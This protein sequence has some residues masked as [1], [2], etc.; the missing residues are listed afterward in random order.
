MRHDSLLYARRGLW[1]RAAMPSIPRCASVVRGV[2]PIPLGRDL[3]SWPHMPATS[4]KTQ[5]CYAGPQVSGKRQA[6][7]RAET[8]DRVP[9]I[10]IWNLAGPRSREEEWAARARLGPTRPFPFSLFLFFS[11]LFCFPSPFEFKFQLQIM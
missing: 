11:F 4:R 6:G 2:R 10:G 9:P 3:T 8:D 5:I 7:A 1:T